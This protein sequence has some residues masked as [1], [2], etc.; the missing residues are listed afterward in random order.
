M[1]VKLHIAT[2]LLAAL[3]GNLSAQEAPS[4]TSN[5]LATKLL[6]IDYGMMNPELEETKISNGLEITY[7][8][9]INRW[10]NIA[11]PVKFGLTT[12]AGDLNKT[13]LASI[14]AILQLQYFN[15]RN[16]MI[17]Y[18][19]GG[20]GIVS[21]NFA[22]SNFQIPFGLGL[23]YELGKN[24]YLT[25][26]AEFRKS[27]LAER[28]NMQYGLGYMVKLGAANTSEEVEEKKL[29]MNDKDGDG[30][31]DKEDECPNDFGDKSFYGCPD[32][33]GD[34]IPDPD[35]E[36]PK[37][38]G[39]LASLGCPDA[40]ND[41]IPDKEDDCPNAVGTIKTLGCPDTD[42][43]GL[44]DSE[45][46]CPDIAGKKRYFGCPDEDKVLAAAEKET[47]ETE[48]K[49][50]EIIPAK[51]EIVQEPSWEND[52]DKDGVLDEN[53]ACPTE[54]GSRNSKGCPDSDGDGFTDE[55]DECPL[56]K[57]LINGCPDSD[58][59]GINDAND[60]CPDEKGSS[61]SNGC[62]DKNTIEDADLAIL[63]NATKD[64]RFE[65][66]SNV[67]ENSSYEVLDEIKETMLR[68]PNYRLMIE[69][70]TDDAGD[71]RQNQILSENRAKACYNYLINAGVSPLNIQYIGYG[72]M[73]PIA[74]N[75]SKRGRALNR[76]V[77]FK[78]EMK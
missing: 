8:R 27:M 30:I 20:G 39:K 78:L 75:K 53:D 11:A 63:M 60:E 66:N 28:N 2:M 32:A 73:K 52:K 38:A 16:K 77:D 17:P 34:G 44:A 35:D 19:F 14:D 46:E 67:L 5:A 25:V 24:S 42:G 13:T 4:T 33:D 51:K 3:F 49:A 70:H 31:S 45:D 65:T 69:G 22:T 36:C 1:R 23:N 12:F 54:P 21:E 9:N 59:D 41:G 57:G 56:S 55:V 50:E 61:A 18:V 26:Q 7:L 58:K 6:F 48:S 71:N 62:P 29:Q 10:V 37:H 43:D 64:I 15:G 76:R 68:Y 47:S 40:D 72:E 74:D